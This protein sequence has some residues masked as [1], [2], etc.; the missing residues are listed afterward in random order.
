M[1]KL[2]FSH[3]RCL[4]PGWF[5]EPDKSLGWTGYSTLYK[6]IIS[7]DKA[8]VHKSS[9]RIYFINIRRYFQD[10]FVILGTLVVTSLAHL[11]NSPAYMWWIP[12]PKSTYLT[13]TALS[14]VF[15]LC[16]LDTPSF[17]RPFSTVASCDS[18]HIDDI[19]FREDIRDS[20]L[21][22]KYVLCILK[23]GF[24]IGTA[25]CSFHNIRFLLWNPIY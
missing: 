14:R 24:Y 4:W 13:Q 20:N 15:V 11:W 16:Q 19:A 18:G 9:C 23:L 6:D 7:T 22:S 10:T 3:S 21:A 5:S 1:H 17:H 12:W 25:N 2:R 8:V